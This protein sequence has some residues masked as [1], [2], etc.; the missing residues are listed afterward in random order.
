MG[1]Y[2][3]KLPT[4][5]LIKQIRKTTISIVHILLLSTPLLIFYKMAKFLILE[6]TIQ[7]FLVN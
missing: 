4:I 5:R 1:I 7:R 2:N 3:L 6:K